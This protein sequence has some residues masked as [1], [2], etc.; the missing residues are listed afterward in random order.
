MG[1]S[2]K[3]EC[4]VPTVL[5]TFVLPLKTNHLCLVWVDRQSVL[6][7]AF[8]QHRHDAVRIPFVFTANDKIIGK[9]GY[10]ASSM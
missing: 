9:S 8:G 1:K 3:I 7:E 5:N 2:E 6:C 4:A 10:E